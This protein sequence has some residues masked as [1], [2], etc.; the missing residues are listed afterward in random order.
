MKTLLIIAASIGVSTVVHGQDLAAI[1]APITMPAAVTEKSV[2]EAAKEAEV[3]AI[4]IGELELVS[5]MEKTLKS[6]LGIE[7]D[8]R[9]FLT[10]KWTPVSVAS[11][12]VWN[13]RI[14]QTPSAGLATSSL[15]RFRLESGD[16]RLGEWQMLFRAQLWRK[17]W[18]TPSRLE[19]GLAL[20]PA[21]LQPVNADVLAENQAPVPADTDV[22]LYEAAQNINGDQFLTWRDLAPRQVIRKGQIVEVHASEGALN[23]SMKGMAL[24]GGGIG[25]EIMIRNL[26]SRRD[27]AARIIDS[28]AVRVNF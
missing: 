5:A 1:L 7:G 14:L 28:T 22:T 11:D 21:M 13:V 9:L 16:Q 23:I 27:I 24:A 4:K 19:R 17:V 25:Q 12:K 10:Q 15:V 20:S 18:A 2:S 26:D 8:L 6:H 3:P